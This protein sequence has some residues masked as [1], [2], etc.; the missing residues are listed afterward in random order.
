MD[1]Q[2]KVSSTL[3]STSE[4]L[5]IIEELSP[6]ASAASLGKK[7]PETTSKVGVRDPSPIVS[8]GL[9]YYSPPNEEDYYVAPGRKKY[10]RDDWSFEKINPAPPTLKNDQIIR[11]KFA[12]QDF[13]KTLR[14]QLYFQDVTRRVGP[15]DTIKA[16]IKD[17]FYVKEQRWFDP[18]FVEPDD[19]VFKSKEAV[20]FVVNYLKKH[21]ENPSFIEHN[22][23]TQ[24]AL[25]DYLK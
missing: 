15:Q 18:D 7:S 2:L 11:Q 1:Q 13:L 23:S 16:A 25:E 24:K 6:E 4:S 12:I 10:E 14:N 19:E 22:D 8:S 20:Q 21:R 9:E 17:S 5:H 3:S